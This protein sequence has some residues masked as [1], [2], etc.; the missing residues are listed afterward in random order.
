[1]NSGKSYQLIHEQ[2]EEYIFA[3]T[4]GG[5]FLSPTTTSYEIPQG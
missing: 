3:D 1:M 4:L 2:R 5:N